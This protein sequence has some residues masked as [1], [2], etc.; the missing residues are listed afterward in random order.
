MPRLLAL[1]CP[2]C[3]APLEV[4]DDQERVLCQFCGSPVV[5]AT[6]PRLSPAE[7]ASVVASPPVLI[8]EKLDIREEP[9]G[10][11]ISWSWIGASLLF[12]IPFCIAWNAFL[13]GW[14]SMVTGFMGGTMPGPMRLIFLV[15]PMAHV[16]VG[17]GL[18]YIVVAM[19]LNRTTVRVRQGMLSVKHGP[20]YYPGG[21]EIPVELIDQLYCPLPLS[22]P[23][24]NGALPVSSPG[25]VRHPL[26][27]RLKSGRSVPLLPSV[28][29][30]DV[31]QAVE[32]LIEKHLGIKDRPVPV[33]SL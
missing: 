11:T 24:G 32:Q 25:R 22:L 28:T 26:C 4:G 10:L 21:R 7:A 14:Y 3:N 27:V 18:M 30:T 16:A 5:V 20:I 1:K 31:A 13:I 12:L 29:G 33:Q 15:F 23:A 6:A 9:E 8:P 17:L 2:S 19:L